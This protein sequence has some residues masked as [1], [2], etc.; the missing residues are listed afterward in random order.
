MCVLYVCR[1]LYVHVCLCT[2]MWISE[3]NMECFLPWLST[4]LFETG[5][6]TEHRTQPLKLDWVS[7]RAPEIFLPLSPSTVIVLFVTPYFV[8]ECW[9]REEQGPDPSVVFPWEA[10]GM[11]EQVRWRLESLGQ[12]SGLWVILL[13]PAV[14]FLVLGWFRIKGL[15][16][17]S[18][19]EE[20]AGSINSGLA[21]FH[22]KG[23]FPG[24][25][26]FTV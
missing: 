3:A 2:C 9:V 15:V 1:Y 17:E 4:L 26:R 23:I 11:A 25:C 18:S 6:L 22:M 13:V 14:Q 24:L 21:S 12:F 19:P 8:Y 20:V 7:S 5:F 10:V 16:T